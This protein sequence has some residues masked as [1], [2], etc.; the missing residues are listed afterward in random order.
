MGLARPG[1]STGRQPGCRQ[2]SD[3]PECGVVAYAKSRLAWLAARQQVQSEIESLGKEV[4]AA[5]EEDGTA[6]ENAAGYR[7][8]ISPVLENF[9]VSLADKLDEAVNA[10]DPAKHAKLVAEAKQ[11]MQRYESFLGSPLIDTV[12]SNPYRPVS[13]RAPIAQTLAAL[14]RTI[15]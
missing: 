3:Q 7:E 15:R 9:D 6:E 8:W 1:R 13:I 2:G 11:I 12:E 5:F 10:T 4:R 14:S